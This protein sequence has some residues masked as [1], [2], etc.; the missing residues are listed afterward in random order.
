LSRR[1]PVSL[2]EPPAEARVP[3]TLLEVLRRSTRHLAASGSETPRLD[4]ELILAHALQVDRIGLYIQF[5]RPLA[6]EELAK[7]RPLLAA[8]AQGRPLAQ[9]LGWREFFGLDFAVNE[10]VLIPRP[11][12]ELLVELAVRLQPGAELA[13]DLGTGSG[14]LGIALAANLPQLRCDLVELDPGAAA[15]ARQ[16]VT[17]HSLEERV[18]VLAGSWAEPL[19]GRGPY[20]LLVANPPYVTTSEWEGL[21]R[22]VR[23]FEPRLALDGGPDG[24]GP[25]RELLPQ[26]P[27][28]AAPGA[29]ILL[30][31]DPR[32]LS[33]LELLAQEAL[34]GAATARHR[35]LAGRERVLEIRLP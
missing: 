10:R 14:C 6:E 31:G 27:G 25:Y 16:N 18:R 26:L 24:L 35:D 30:E 34:S 12:S 8:R 15:V 11:E 19:E 23:D 28:I 9:L 22:T 13:A 21:E 17:R 2:P 1:Q 33:A 7:I 32:R 5:E 3:L 29:L 4:S 20:Q